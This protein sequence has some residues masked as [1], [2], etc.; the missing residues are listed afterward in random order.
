MESETTTSELVN[1]R[2]ATTDQRLSS[3]AR[4]RFLSSGNWE[5]KP[6]ST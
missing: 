1:G 2:K 5:Q 6:S 4:N 3:G